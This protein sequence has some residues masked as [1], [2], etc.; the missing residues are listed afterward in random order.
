MKR[1]CTSCG[2]NQVKV[3]SHLCGSCERARE[4]SSREEAFTQ[5]VYKLAEAAAEANLNGMGETIEQLLTEA[6]GY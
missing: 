5:L 3:R 4:E 2:K 6:R 1:I